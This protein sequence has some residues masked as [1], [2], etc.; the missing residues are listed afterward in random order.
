MAQFIGF[1]D[2]FGRTISEIPN[3]LT[4]FSSFALDLLRKVVG[5]PVGFISVFTTIFIANYSLD[6][7]FSTI[8]NDINNAVQYVVDSVNNLITTLTPA[9]CGVGDIACYIY[10]GLTELGKYLLQG[11]YIAFLYPI[12]YVISAFLQFINYVIKFNMYLVQSTLCFV[13]NNWFPPIVGSYT[14]FK[15]F[16]HLSTWLFQSALGAIHSGSAG[17]GI[18]GILAGLASPILSFIVT[19][20]LTKGLL[21]MVENAFNISCSNIKPPTLNIT[22]QIPQIGTVNH[23]AVESLTYSLFYSVRQSTVNSSDVLTTYGVSGSLATYDLLI[24]AESPVYALS[25]AVASTIMQISAESGSYLLKYA[26]A[27]YTE[28]SSTVAS[29]YSLTTSVLPPLTLTSKESSVYGLSFGSSIKVKLNIS[30][31]TSYSLT[32]AK[33]IG[34]AS[35]IV[36]V[37]SLSITKISSTMPPQSSAESASYSLNVVGTTQGGASSSASGTTLTLTYT[38]TLDGISTTGGNATQLTYTVSD[39]YSS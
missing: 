26:K 24:V 33:S 15:S 6:S 11:V 1:S 9:S 5:N 30:E 17:K 29:K 13:A 31:L 12:S 7:L 37:Y 39:S 19:D 20:S 35:N 27:P 25:Y 18:L 10:S 21:I 32:I 23:N 16:E 22:I 3:Y 14:A 28:L 38:M 36:N 4:R 34:L 8:I 2:I